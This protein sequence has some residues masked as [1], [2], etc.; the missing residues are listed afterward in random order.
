MCVFVQAKRDVGD[1]G[2]AMAD[3]TEHQGSQ[4]ASQNPSRGQEELSTQEGQGQVGIVLV[5]SAN[6]W[7]FEIALI[8]HPSVSI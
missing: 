6:H 8:I 1:A 4:R 5:S 2:D 3:P 7:N